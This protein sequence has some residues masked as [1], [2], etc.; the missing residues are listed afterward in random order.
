MLLLWAYFSR[1]FFS[2]S[3]P[4]NLHQPVRGYAFMWNRF[5]NFITSMLFAPPFRS[6]ALCES[7]CCPCRASCSALGLHLGRSLSLTAGPR[8]VLPC[9][10]QVQR[11]CKMLTLAGSSSYRHSKKKGE[12]VSQ[13]TT[14]T[15]RV[16]HRAHRGAIWFSYFCTLLSW[17]YFAFGLRH[18]FFVHTVCTISF[19]MSMSVFC[20]LILP[21]SRFISCLARYFKEDYN[22]KIHTT[23]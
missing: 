4:N 23:R 10:L 6:V 16:Y 21:F 18:S 12:I 11:S 1:V 7:F 22:D 5:N 15:K 19:G 2:Y 3:Y 9:P 17:S 20:F 14:T 13:Q 8:M